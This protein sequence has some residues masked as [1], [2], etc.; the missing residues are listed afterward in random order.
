[1]KFPSIRSLSTGIIYSAFQGECRI[2]DQQV[3]TSGQYGAKPRF[4]LD[5]GRSLFVSFA[6][7]LSDL[8]LPVI[9]DIP[10]DRHQ[11]NSLSVPL[12]R[13]RS[14]S[15]T[16]VPGYGREEHHSSSS[17]RCCLSQVRWSDYAGE[18]RCA[19]SFQD[20]S[21]APLP[22]PSHQALHQKQLR[23]G[24]EPHNRQFPLTRRRYERL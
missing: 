15:S 14:P 13:H 9:A 17:Y 16:S 20:Y 21:P 23:R 10:R 11:I 2:D 7:F 24:E 1:M 12:P 18:C 4:D 6:T 5:R 22:H 19:S 8:L 3:L